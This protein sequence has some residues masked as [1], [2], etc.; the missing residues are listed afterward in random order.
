MLL[1]KTAPFFM[2]DKADKTVQTK[3]GPCTLPIR[4]FSA[5]N[6]MMFFA[7]DQDRAR[8]LLPNR[9][10]EPLPNEQGKALAL[11]G[12]WDYYDTSIGPYNE[13]TISLM[14]TYPGFH[15]P[16]C[17]VCSLPV[18]TEIA[19]EAGLEIFRYPKFVA[20]S[21]VALEGQQVALSVVLQDGTTALSVTGT[22]GDSFY[23]P[24]MAIN[25]YAEYVEAADIGRVVQEHG[26]ATVRSRSGKN[27]SI[28]VSHTTV[29]AAPTVVYCVSS[30][31]DLVL[32]AGN[33]DHFM[34]QQVQTLGL[35]GKSPISIFV[36]RNFQS[37]L[38]VTYEGANKA[39]R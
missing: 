7:V 9:Q 2:L 31:A 13:S 30:G 36:S 38:G 22:R 6:V 37:V 20:D 8:L 21:R 17:Y 26:M 25:T 34:K 12:F 4:Y 11:V 27:G 39:V 15:L 23:S 10:F 33:S 32:R 5:C 14:V 29:N 24:P 3:A 28:G 19:C 16:G 18:S 1:D 35:D